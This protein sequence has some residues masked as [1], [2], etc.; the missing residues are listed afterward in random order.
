MTKEW[1]KALA[2]RVISTAAETAIATIGAATMI[3]EVNWKTVASATGLAVVLAVL[4]NLVK[5]PT[6][7]KAVSK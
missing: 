1:A 4:K 3:G 6:E 5:K 2:E 7:V